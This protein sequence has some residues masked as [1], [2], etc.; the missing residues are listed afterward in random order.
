MTL[1]HPAPAGQWRAALAVALTL[2]F[3]FAGLPGA[4]AQDTVT[5]AFQGTVTS[6]DTGDPVAGAA[7]EVVHRETGQTY[8]KTSDSLGRWYQGLLQPGLYTIRVS[9][10]G[11][12]TKEVSQRLFIAKANEAIP[13]PVTLDPLPAVAATP[14]PSTTATPAASPAPGAA[15]TPATPASVSVVTQ[16][17]TDVRARRSTTDAR[18]GGSFT[19]EEVSLLPLGSSTFTRTF[20]E[21]ALLLPGVAPPP[22]TLGSVAGPGVGAGVG[23]AGQFAVN[24][25]RSRGNNFTVDGSD[26]NDEDIGVRRQGFVALNSQPIES[27]REYQ[28][29]TLLAPAQFGR[30]I[31]AQVNAVSKSGGSS[32]H[33]SVY[34]FFNSSRLNA[35]NPFDTANGNATVALRGVG[36]LPVI[37]ADDIRIDPLTLQFNPVNPRPL[38]VTNQS[39]GE[40]S[41]TLGQ[42]GLAFGGP[43]Q[44]EGRGG[45][46]RLFYFVSAEGYVQNATR[47]ESFAVPR[48]GQ[49]GAFASGETGLFE[50][51][52]QRLPNGERQPLQFVPTSSGGDAIFSLFPFPN[53]PRG[54]YGANTFTQ[55]LPNGAKGK[56]ASGKIDANFRALGRQHSLTNRYNFTDDRRD[57]PVVGGALFSSLRAQ[58][59]TQNNSFFFNSE[60][61]GPDSTKQIFNQVRLSYGRTRLFFEEL[62]DQTFQLPNTILPGEPFL[63]NAPLLENFTAPRVID[64]VRF[65]PN[66]GA[67][68]YLATPGQTTQN[69][70]R[71][72]PTG[73]VNRLGAVGQINIAGFSPVGVDVFNFPQRRVNNT[74]QVADELTL[75][76][77]SHTWVFGAD[78]RRS[79]LNSQLPRNSRPLITFAGAAELDP[80]TLQF[81]GDFVR[82]ETLAAASAPTGVFQTLALNGEQ[83]IGLRYYQLNFYGQDTWRVR[84][85]LLVSAGLRYEYNTPPR[86]VNNRIERSFS[87]PLLR[88]VPGLQRFIGGRDQIF[89]PDRNNFAPRV[90]VAYSPDLF[91]R[92]DR[93][94]VFRAGYGRFYDQI[95]GAVVSQS[96]NVYPDYLTIN[97]GGGGANLTGFEQIPGTDRFRQRCPEFLLTRCQ[98]ELLLP[99]NPIPNLSDP[100]TAGAV[101]L[102]QPGTLNQLNPN[103]PFSEFVRLVNEIVRGGGFAPQTSGFGATLPAQELETPSAD[104]YSASFEQQFGPSLALSVAYVGT[105]GRNLLRFTT[106]NLGPNTFVVLAGI[107]PAPGLS[108]QGVVLEPA[109]FGLTL[110]PGSRPANERFVGGR[111]VPSAGAVFQFE[112]SARSW[113]NSIQ[114]QARTRL[115]RR[116]Q[117]QL[118]YTYGKAID[119]VSDVFDLA[120]ASSLPQDS[121]DLD[122]ERGFANFDVRHRLSYHFIYDLPR[123]ADRSPLTRLLFG[124]VQIAGKGSFNTGQP[125]TINSLFDVNLDGNLTDRLDNTAGIVATG[126]RRRPY[127]LT[128]DPRQLVAP[129]GRNGAVGRN[130]FR[131]SNFFSTDL[132]VVKNFLFAEAQSISLRADIFNLTNR[133][134]YGIP[135]RFLEAPGFGESTD[136]VTP[137]RRVQFALKYNF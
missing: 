101:R 13:V 70:L 5:G 97:F 59:R 134:N 71:L 83:A 82:P 31:G 103:L 42:F 10:P 39:G 41:F 128:A 135:V 115:G 47:E 26:N 18:Q 111:P 106:P 104:H 19:E 36:G 85:N 22:Q 2:T 62:R 126:D 129:I 27:V 58:V 9:A 48:V 7:V 3:I 136:I 38:T 72:G 96:R 122:G 137:M 84:Q 73:L 46:A 45:G 124:G 110:A 33:G 107:A 123:F 35:R 61:S 66:N 30:N 127:V 93:A 52:F 54:V 120:G 94:S 102:V 40:D 89:S 17:E 11:F 21:L 114:A 51:P 63:L 112:T 132:A 56:I 98:F 67:I 76:A 65:G 131:A 119:D 125:F 29:I 108:G 32:T 1:E 57:I 121:F 90:S 133:A 25:L 74:Y 80:E 24:G 4:S 113:Y 105:R 50:V 91:G 60:L 77:G 79:E 64:P 118:S 44:P 116:F 23:S 69:S 53:N 12:Q 37:V 49:R 109:F 86:E 68:L 8:A 87:D 117:G 14:T 130:T 28:A 16:E 75:H 55:I 81:T 34:G 43:L 99:A 92:G 20:D 88:F 95:L 78:L 6:S 100:R 15:A